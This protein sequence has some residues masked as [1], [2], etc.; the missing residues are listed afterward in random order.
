M[1]KKR[2]K[3]QTGIKI[4]EKDFEDKLTYFVKYL[5]ERLYGKNI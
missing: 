2:E 1:V 3:I 5:K 4:L